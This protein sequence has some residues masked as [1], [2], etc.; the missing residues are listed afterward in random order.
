MAVVNLNLL[1]IFYLKTKKKSIEYEGKTI[2]EV[3]SKFIKE[4][5]QTLDGNLLSK[6]KKKLDK[7]I[8]ILLNG[9]NIKYL[10]NYKTKLNDGDQ[11]HLSVP[12]AGG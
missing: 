2:K 10:N 5:G 9:R 3:L 8:L 4:N 6:N 12:L 1:N 7:Q 11:I